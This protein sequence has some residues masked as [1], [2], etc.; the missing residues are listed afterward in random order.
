MGPSFYLS[1][2][3]LLRCFCFFRFSPFLLIEINHLQWITVSLLR[4]L[5]KAFTISS[6]KAIAIVCEHMRNALKRKQF[7]EHL[8]TLFFSLTCIVYGFFSSFLFLERYDV[9]NPL[10]ILLPFHYIFCVFH[11]FAIY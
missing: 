3:P 5:K 4:I 8:I 6:C 7:N 9:P 2:F 11:D 10:I 1:T